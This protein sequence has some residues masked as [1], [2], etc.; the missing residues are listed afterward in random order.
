M[1]GLSGFVS[2]SSVRTAL[3]NASCTP[4]I[5][6]MPYSAMVITG[7]ALGSTRRRYG[8]FISVGSLSRT[9]AIESRISCEASI[10]FLSNSNTITMVPTL[11]VY[12]LQLLHPSYFYPA[13]CLI[14]AI[15]ALAIGFT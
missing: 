7:C 9:V 10:R 15:V 4:A 1:T 12:G 8:S 14:C 3:K 11:I 5:A 2:T 6:T 13:T